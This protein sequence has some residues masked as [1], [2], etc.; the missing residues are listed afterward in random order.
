MM[1]CVSTKSTGRGGDMGGMATRPSSAVI[2]AGGQQPSGRP[3]SPTPSGAGTVSVRSAP[4]ASTGYLS[5]QGFCAALVAVAAKTARQS[6][7][8]LEACPFLSEQLRA[9]VEAIASKAQRV[10]P[11][12]QAAKKGGTASSGNNN[13]QKGSISLMDGTKDGIKVPVS[14]R[15]GRGRSDKAAGGGSGGSPQ[16]MAAIAE[17]SVAPEDSLRGG[18]DT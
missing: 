7:E 18:L 17:A 15:T 10:A 11:I 3:P 2:G 14:K 5:F 9:Y 6:G 8:L 12:A 1:R 4:V 16:A 13:T